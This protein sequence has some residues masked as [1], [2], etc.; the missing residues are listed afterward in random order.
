MAI[1]SLGASQK[2][3]KTIIGDIPIEWDLKRIEEIAAINPRR[4]QIEDNLLVSFVTMSDVSEQ[5]K[6]S[7]KVE[8]WFKEIPNGFTPFKNGDILIAKITP[9]FEN[10]KGALADGLSNGFGFGS[11]EFHIVRPTDRVNKVF[12][13]YH[14]ISHGFR[15]RGQS[16]MSGSAGQKRV[17][18]D[19]IKS[20]HIPLPPLSEQKAIAETLSTW[21]RAIEKI[22]QL[23]QAKQ[24]LK[25][26]LMYQLLTGKRR[27]KEF[28]REE[29][30]DLLLQAL[31]DPVV[32]PVPKPN[33]SYRALGLR[34]HGKGTF[35]RIVEDPDSVMMDTLYKIEAGDLIVNIT[36]AWEG[37]IA[38]AEEHDEG[39]LVSHRFPIYRFRHG[40]ADPDYFRQ[41][42][43][44][45]RFVFDIG[46]I[47]PG[48][49]GRNRVMSK[50]DFL[51]LKVRI[52]DL[53]E[54]RKIGKL[55]YAY[56]SEIDYLKKKLNAWQQQ[57]K[58]LMQKLLT[59]KIRVRV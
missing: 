34:S 21:D 33:S 12:L 15:K 36:F 23:I 39:T 42:I 40:I 48:G 17:P 9:C 7:N 47:S 46:L 30:R 58:G 29:W 27:F 28:R 1:K 41:L 16:T 20:Y 5:G 8:K 51:K 18:A 56:D 54:Q 14:T 4:D 31:I 53:I 49:A 59:G 57:K 19:F 24:K 25:K 45:K 38:I 55:L 6:I 32:R 26:G 22:T 43:L 35:Q 2:M 52:P 10:G 44:T 37:A 11:T 13:F 50:T 3:K